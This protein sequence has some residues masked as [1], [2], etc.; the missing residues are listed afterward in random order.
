MPAM[1]TI[2]QL[3][4]GVHRRMPVEVQERQHNRLEVYGERLQPMR[5]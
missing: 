1:R 2:R 4:E 3:E 5:V